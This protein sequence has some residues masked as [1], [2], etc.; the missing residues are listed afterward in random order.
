MLRDLGQGER[1]AGND[2]DVAHDVRFT[3]RRCGDC[4]RAFAIPLMPG[5]KEKLERFDWEAVSPRLRERDLFVRIPG[6][7]AAV[8]PRFV[9]GRLDGRCVFLEDD[10]GCLIHQQLGYEAKPLACRL[11]PFVLALEPFGTVVSASFACSSV[12]RQEGAPLRSR[13]SEIS[14]LG[15]DPLWQAAEEA[16]VELGGR[17][18]VPERIVLAADVGLDWYSYQALER[19]MVAMLLE[20]SHTLA[21][22]L[23]AIYRLVDGAVAEYGRGS[24]TTSPFATWMEHMT[25]GSGERWLYRAE[26]GDSSGSPGRQRAGLAPLISL[27][28]ARWGPERDVG[29]QRWPLGQVVALARGRGRVFLHSLESEI[30]LEEMDRVELDQDSPA[31]QPLLVSYLEECLRRKALLGYPNVLKGTR[32][33]LV[34]LALVR[35]YS[36]AAAVARGRRRAGIEEVREAIRTVE[37]GYAHHTLLP[38]LLAQHGPS[39][40]L[41][42]LLLDMACSPADL[43]TNFYVRGAVG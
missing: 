7:V 13:E 42:T 40:F 1:V 26:P 17:V 3:C 12:A 6:D 5:E 34:Y 20:P 24:K 38:R 37:A 33:L 29:R 43:I 21:V 31:L 27:V 39:S 14:S 11:F 30:G 9:L 19:A 8:E 32:Y 2:L 28:E 22:R 16:G 4:C 41:V 35:W 25:R 23:L 36:V 15:H 10:N 18:R